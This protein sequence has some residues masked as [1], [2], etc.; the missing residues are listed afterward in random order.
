MAVWW[1]VRRR[2]RGPWPAV[3][4]A[5]AATALLLASEA[6]VALVGFFGGAGWGPITSWSRRAA[7]LQ[8]G[9]II[10]CALT[11]LAAV[12]WDVGHRCRTDGLHRAGVLAWLWIATMQ[13]VACAAS[14]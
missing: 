9:A 1:A 14:R 12:A 4:L 6:I 3:F 5:F 2:L 11:L 7:S 10:V 13:L 8:V